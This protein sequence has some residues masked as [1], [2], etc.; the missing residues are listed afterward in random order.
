LESILRLL[1]SLKIRAQAVLL[2][3]EKRKTK[4]EVVRS[5][6]IAGDG[7]GGGRGV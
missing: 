3:R 6:D 7:G 1:K 4:R 2:H 5:R